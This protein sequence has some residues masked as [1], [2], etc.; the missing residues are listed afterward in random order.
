MFW[1]SITGDE[2]IINVY[3]HFFNPWQGQE[4]IKQARNQTLPNA[5][6]STQLYEDK[7]TNLCLSPIRNLNRLY[8]NNNNTK[9]IAFW[10]NVK[11][12]QHE[13]EPTRNEPCTSSEIY[14]NISMQAT[15]KRM[16]ISN[17]AK[18]II[19]CLGY[20]DIQ[21][22]IQ[23]HFHVHAHTS[24]SRTLILLHTMQEI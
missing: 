24:V 20:M 12:Q 16:E 3:L 1:T 6:R 17:G 11:S 13:I 23:V 21:D 4:G 10:R 9:W 8:K 19:C 22:R 14:A 5:W 7:Q 18:T 2:R 15:T